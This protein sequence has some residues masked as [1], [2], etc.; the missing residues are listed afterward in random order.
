MEPILLPLEVLDALKKNPAARRKAACASHWWFFRIYFGEY[1][2]YPTAAMQDAM[3]KLADDRSWSLLVL[4]AFRGSAKSTI[5]TLSY[6][7]WSIMGTPKKK[8]VLIIAKTIEQA[9]QFLKNIR[10]ECERNNLL[11]SDLG[12]FD[13]D[14]QWTK[15]GLILTQYDAKIMAISVGQA[16]RSLRHGHN[17]PDLIICDDVEDMAS[18]QSLEMRD[19]S[20]DWVI[21][22]ILGAGDLNTQTVVI[23]NYLHED[24]LTQRLRIEMRDKERPGIYREYP[25]LTEDGRCLWPEKFPTKEAIERFKSQF[26]EETWYREFL[27]KTLSTLERVIQEEW[28]QYYDYLP[29]VAQSNFLYAA[30]G[31]DLAISDKESADC[32]AMVSA[33]FFEENEVPIVY[34]LP[35]PINARIPFPE[36]RET[37]IQLSETIGRPGIFA[38]IIIEDVAYQRAL[39]QEL[40]NEG[41]PASGSKVQQ[42]DKRSR[43]AIVSH[44]VQAGR[45][46]FPREG[47]GE[48]ISQLVNFGRT[49][50][51]DLADAFTILL[52]ER[53]T[54][55]QI[56]VF[57]IG[58]ENNYW[59]NRKR[60][61]FN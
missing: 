51:D 43:L 37:A 55:S 22:E 9:Q 1:I 18:V 39:I 34:I 4:V 32:T 21:G 14:D 29:S 41:Y 49:R 23:G 35:N 28:I 59:S 20:Y 27:L 30:T 19:K 26:N 2:K 60:R 44:H 56:S 40:E 31:I 53:K 24:S 50:H 42:Q 57:L 45:V 16:V 36:Q 11:T 46:L 25:L 15:T 58:G 6:V 48:L 10:T 13:K 52:M 7:L 33:L 38:D 61:M 12:P 47:A 54:P 3:F 17:R 5:W 8:F